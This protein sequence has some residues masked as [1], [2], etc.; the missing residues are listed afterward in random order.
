M[1]TCVCVWL[2]KKK[3]ED[4]EAHPECFVFAKKIMEGLKSVHVVRVQTRVCEQKSMCVCVCVYVC[5]CL[6]NQPLRLLML[7]QIDA[8]CI[9][10]T[11]TGCIC[12][13]YI[14]K[15]SRE[16]LVEQDTSR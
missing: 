7:A 10:S 14:G 15:A 11:Q 1:Y 2:Q 4:V 12:K 13:R 5:M 3:T 9:F 16:C 8:R 6:I